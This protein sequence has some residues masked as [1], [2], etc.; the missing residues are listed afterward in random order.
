MSEQDISG[1]TE[2]NDEGIKKHFDRIEPWEA[3]SELVWNGFDAGA[4]DVRVSVEQDEMDTAKKVFVLDDGE[5]IDYL[6]IKDNFGRFN[7]SSKKGDLSQHG[8]HGR[9]RLAFYRLCHRAVWY[10][11]NVH[12]CA[13]ITV[14]GSNIKK[15][16][17]KAGINHNAIPSALR[18]LPS[19]TSVMLESFSEN[20]PENARLR[21]LLSRELGWYLA[22]NPKKSLHVN[23]VRVSGPA[24]TVTDETVSVG[25]Y[26]FLISIIRWHEKPNSEKS[27]FYLLN[28]E[29]RVEHKRLSTFNQKPN[30]YTSIYIK[31][32]WANT[33]KGETADLLTDRDSTLDSDLW[34]KVVKCVSD[35]AEEI[36]QDFLREFIDREMDSYEEGGIFPSY[37]GISKPYADWRLEHTKKIVRTLYT[38]DPSILQ[39]LNKKQKKIVVRLIDRLAIS[40]ENDALFEIISGVLDLNSESLEQLGVQLKNTQLDHVISTIEAIQQRT[41]TVS[42]LREIMNKHYKE[43]L[44]TPDLQKVI[45][46]NTWLFGHQYETIGAEED[47]FT[48]I[49]KEL[50][51]RVKGIDGL[52]SDDFDPS[53]SMEIAGA[54]RQTDLFLAR[55][56]PHIDDAGRRI[57]KCTI[58]EIKRPGVS[59]NIKHLRQLDDYAAIISKHPEYSSGSIHFDLILVGRKISAEDIEIPSRLN[60]HRGKGRP[61][62]VSDDGKVKRYVLNWYTLLDDLELAQQYLLEKLQIKRDSFELE[63]KETLLSALQTEFV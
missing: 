43:V 54:Q 16:E 6:S 60:A 3:I 48:K 50:R 10:T 14:L 55:K 53:E 47:T 28:S 34:K 58:I 4:T 37:Q 27:Y 51:A 26:D 42:M 7:D 13:S 44:E 20:L 56:R 15:Y 33:I 45:E 24:N 23:G 11:K 35:M 5:G 49:A 21:D 59:L 30:F 36:Y 52:D 17:G 38:A 46:A 9:G 39:S 62:L 19:G 31:S 57:Y 61:G 29:G 22:L 2:I 1:T 32:D 8:R 41:S 63:D 25:G 12:G 18:A 40:N